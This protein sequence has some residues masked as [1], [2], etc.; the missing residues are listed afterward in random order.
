MAIELKLTGAESLA[1]W[2]RRAIRAERQVVA[3]AEPSPAQ[4]AV[5]ESL[6]D[7]YQAWVDAGGLHEH[8]SR[9]LELLD[10]LMTSC[11]IWLD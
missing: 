8:G 2:R 9:V 1:Y 7:L 3:M 10:E 4:N 6:S 5:A 11:D